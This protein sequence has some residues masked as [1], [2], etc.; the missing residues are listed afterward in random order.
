MYEH[1]YV[2]I[3]WAVSPSLFQ[4]EADFAAF[5]LAVQG[6]IDEIAV[7][8][9]QVVEDD[10]EFEDGGAGISVGGTSMAYRLREG[11]ERFFISDINNPAA[12]AQ[13]QS[14]LP[15][16]WDE[17]SGGEASHFNHVPGGC[18]VLYMD[19]HVGFTRYVTGNGA[20]FP[21]N[22][23]GITLHEATHAHH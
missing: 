18:T 22:G 17:V 3:G 14:E 8:G 13:A 23:G 2:Y 10:W 4:A 16:M 20:P 1:P 7:D 19:G 11:I 5:E 12:S 15:V 9:A 21:V 6:L